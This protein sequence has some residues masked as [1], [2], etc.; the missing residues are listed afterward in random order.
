MLVSATEL[1]TSSVLISSV[2][3]DGDRRIPH[4]WIAPVQINLLDFI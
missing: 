1:Y 4:D 3:K 2:V